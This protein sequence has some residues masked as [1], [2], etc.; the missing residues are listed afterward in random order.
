M[1]REYPEEE[2][3]VSPAEAEDDQ[4]SEEASDQEEEEKPYEWE[5][6]IFAKEPHDVPYFT[7]LRIGISE[8]V[9]SSDGYIRKLEDVF[10]SSKGFVLPGT[11]YRTY[12]VEI[13]KNEIEEYYVHDLIWRAFHGDP[14]EG[15]EV[16]HNY[17]ETKKNNENY[18]NALADLEIYP[19]TV[20]YMPSI[21]R[22]L[23]EPGC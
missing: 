18:S 9:I 8:L 14:P 19:S 23:P 22:S 3:V 6:D 4:E 2:E 15:W 11:P 20:T 17:W 21:R 7:I 1:P 13:Q 16:R 5:E 10:S 12:P